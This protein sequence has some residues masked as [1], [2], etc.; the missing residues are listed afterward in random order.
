MTPC[1]GHTPAVTVYLVVQ[2]DQNSPGFLVLFPGIIIP[3]VNG[4]AVHINSA[5]RNTGTLCRPETID[6]SFALQCPL[7]EKLKVL[8]S[9]PFQV[10]HLARRPARLLFPMETR[11][12]ETSW[13]RSLV[14]GQNRI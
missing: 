1:L 12:P 13:V 2:A 5:F 10:V 6:L 9:G 3:E 14:Q 4:I 8:M 7:K 11:G